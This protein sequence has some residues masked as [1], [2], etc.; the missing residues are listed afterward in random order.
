MTAAGQTISKS[1][2]TGHV[3]HWAVRYDLLVWFVMRGNERA[4]RER[5]IQLARLESGDKVLDVGCGTGTLAVAARRYVGP[6]G[7]VCGI[8][9]SPEMIARARKKAATAGVEIEFREALAE[10]LPFP[11]A[12]FDAVLSTVML[13]HLGPK[14][15]RQCAAEVR[16]VLKPSGRWLVID[17]EGSARHAGG[18]LSRFHRHGHIKPGDLSALISEAGFK[19]IESGPAGFRN[20]HFV[21]AAAPCIG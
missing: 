14:L 10:A 16:R 9:A 4:F 2:T 20:L 3:L 13:H 12:H 11:D 18:I 7:I 1:E 17:F 5:Q 21:L 6:A 8:D 15:R 19:T